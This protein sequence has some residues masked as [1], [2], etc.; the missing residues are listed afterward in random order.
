M[1]LSGLDEGEG[2]R[3]GSER[4]ALSLRGYRMSFEVQLEV[5]VRGRDEDVVG[6]WTTDTCGERISTW[7]DGWPG[8][9]CELAGEVW[10]MDASVSGT[11]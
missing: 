4:R 8:W 3:S 10:L 6:R 1:R 5:G 11:A 2:R 7:T 9:I